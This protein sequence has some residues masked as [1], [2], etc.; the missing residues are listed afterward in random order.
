M[1]MMQTTQPKNRPTATRRAR[2]ARGSALLMALMYVTLFAALASSMTLF[3]ISS[4]DVAA[5]SDRATRAYAAA[6]SGMTFLN[7]Q[8][9]QLAKPVTAAGVVDYTLAQ[10]LFGGSGGIAQKLAAQL[11]G[12]TNL[13]GLSVIYN[14]TTVRI[15]PI[16]MFT[17]ADDTA[18]V[19]EIDQD[20]GDARILHLTSTGRCSNVMKS[21]TM[22]VKIEKVLKYAIYSNVAIQIGKNAIVE[23]DIVSTLTGFTK[24]PP[25]W[26]LS[27]WRAL[28]DEPTLDSDLV[29]FR[30][31]IASGNKNTAFDNR[32]DV[33]TPAAAAAA[34]AQG[35]YDK[36]GDGFI[37]DWDIALKHL[38]ANGD[39]SLSSGEFTD[40]LTGL[41]Y[42]QQL[43]NLVDNLDPPL[44]TGGA[45]RY[46]YEDGK[47]DALDA[48]AKVKGTVRV[49]VT[50]AAWNTWANDSSSSG[51]AKY[52]VGFRE[53]FQGPVI[54]SDPTVAPVEFAID[55][56]DVPPILP[57]NFDTSAY[58]AQSGTSAGA[59]SGS[60]ASGTIKD[61]TITT[62][63]AN[64]GTITEGTPYGSSSIEATYKRPVFQNV[65]FTN[66]KIPT[67]L[68]AKF[69][70]C[71][72][73]GVTYVD[74]QTNITNTAGQTTTDPND[75]MTWSKKMVSGSFSSTT[76]LTA[77]NSYGFQNGNNLRFDNCT[78]TGPLAAANPTAY[79]HFANSWEFTGATMFNN[80]TDPT[81]TILAPNT[82]IEMGSFT[83]PNAAPSTLIGVVVAGNIDI[84]GSS[85]I[86]GSIIVT[87]NGATNTTLAYFGADDS[88]SDPN[89]MPVGGY[90]RL[91]MRYNPTRA[92]PNGI[93]I[94]VSL[95]PNITSYAPKSVA[96]WG[97]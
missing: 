84:R 30:A 88:T 61:A 18:F 67:G 42:D 5:G 6:E 95:T 40:P 77:T 47:L 44:Q 37:D 60:V 32:L 75:G 9:K 86:D 26:M 12:T 41:S 33:R 94:P 23:G 63:M 91:Y 55:S 38:D 70:N 1:L 76:P 73:N 90:G 85:T 80:V 19:L 46:G 43:F 71:T 59:T 62:A 78:F 51:G 89:A 82:N 11:N 45:T 54:S 21:V 27:D 66:C 68:N 56:T 83:D 57:A 87:G 10:T 7:L 53:Q 64:G 81:A 65:S 14:T 49:G 96:V 72:F 15:P 97:W 2:R 29:N 24:G 34:A 16:K 4:L 28:S 31:Y 36:S 20:A 17:A 58:A 52:G 74:M 25:V 13:Q 8:L 93:S 79:T 48:Y 69:E 39:K 50:E 3:S 35:F 22:D 92:M